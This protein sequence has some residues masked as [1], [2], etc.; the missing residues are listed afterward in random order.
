L[1]TG[2]G[3][4]VG[5]GVNVGN[6]AKVGVGMGVTDTGSIKRKIVAVLS[7]FITLSIPA[8]FAV[9]KRRKT[10]TT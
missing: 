9:F 3:V 6:G 7:V 1:S 4:T 8:L 10:P 2:T 5:V